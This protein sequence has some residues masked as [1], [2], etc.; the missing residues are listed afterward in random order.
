[1][2]SEKVKASKEQAVS[3]VLVSGFSPAGK[4]ESW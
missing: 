2:T 3:E 1:V 4:E